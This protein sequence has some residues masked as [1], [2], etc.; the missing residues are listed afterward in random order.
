[1]DIDIVET[2]AALCLSQSKRA[3][4][5]Y[6]LNLS[7]SWIHYTKD[8]LKHF[9]YEMALEKD[10]KKHVEWYKN[11]A[12]S[13]SLAIILCVSRKLSKRNTIYDLPTIGYQAC[14]YSGA[15]CQMFTVHTQRKRTR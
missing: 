2:M 14:I 11:T 3:K 6:S 12:A 8:H 10:K 15:T 7:H 5:T 1:M 4:P 13:V 9:S